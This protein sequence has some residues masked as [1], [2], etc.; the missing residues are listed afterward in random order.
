MTGIY[1]IKNK[2]NNK[3]YIGSCKDFRKRTNAHKSC[4][5]RNVHHSIKLQ[6][7]YN[8]YGINAFEYLFI[9]ETTIENS[10]AREQYWINLLN[11]GYNCAKLVGGHNKKVTT[12][13]TKVKI[14]ESKNQFKK[15]VYKFNLHGDLIDSYESLTLAA[16]SVN[17]NLIGHIA[18]CCK[19]IRK[20]A[21]GFKWSHNQNIT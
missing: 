12:E 21:Y 5:K 14:S 7:S 20:T 1:F 6:R 11:P 4:L 8:K 15:K 10:L 17:R 19:S 2:L 9:E 13:E 16:K 18:Q 3:I